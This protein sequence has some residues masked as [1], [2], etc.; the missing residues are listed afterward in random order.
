MLSL[1]RLPF[2]RLPSCLLPSCPRR[3]AH[4]LRRRHLP[5]HFD[6]SCSSNHLRRHCQVPEALLPTELHWVG[7]VR[8]RLR[9]AFDDHGEQLTGAVHR[10]TDPG[11]RWHWDDLGG[12]PVPHPRALTRL[13]QCACAWVPHL[14]SAVCSG[15]CRSPLPISSLFYI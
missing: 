12:N 11:R 15:E 8:H 7:G 13:E 2:P 5:A 1:L 9:C 10:D 4:W 6:H 3:I 14:P